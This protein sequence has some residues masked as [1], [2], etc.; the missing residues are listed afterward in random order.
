MRMR[1]F[2]NRTTATST[3]HK[4]GAWWSRRRRRQ[5]TPERQVRPRPS[6]NFIVEIRGGG[7][8]GGSERRNAQGGGREARREP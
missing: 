1:L 4:T 6:D 5:P 8:E 3:L 7:R 2:T